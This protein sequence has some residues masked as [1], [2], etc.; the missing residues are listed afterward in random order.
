VYLVRIIRKGTHFLKTQSV[1]IMAEKQPVPFEKCR[2]HCIFFFHNVMPT[3]FKNIFKH[4]FFYQNIMPT[5]F[6]KVQP[7]KYK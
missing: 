2:G 6:K 7:F 3:A 1:G 5:A 4:I